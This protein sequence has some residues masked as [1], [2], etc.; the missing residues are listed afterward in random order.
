MHTEIEQIMGRQVYSGKVLYLTRWKGQSQQQATWE[1]VKVL[2]NV[3]YLIKDYNKKHK[4][5]VNIDE[6]FAEDQPVIKKKK[7]KIVNKVQPRKRGRPR[8][9]NIAIQR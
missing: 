3:K 8:K 6:D 9:N 2:K 7:E 1:S 5:E 4:I